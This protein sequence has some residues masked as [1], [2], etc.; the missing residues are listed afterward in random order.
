M[1]IPFLTNHRARRQ[2]SD[3]PLTT[4][5]KSNSQLHD[6]VWELNKRVQELT[7]L[8]QRNQHL[9]I[10]AMDAAHTLDD[11]W[12]ASGASPHFTDTE[13]APLLRLLQAARLFTAAEMWERANST[14]DAEPVSA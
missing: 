5:A 9:V 12:L 6:E 2:M 8:S 14:E 11:P 13:L 1:R 4:L 10:A 3:T 7:K